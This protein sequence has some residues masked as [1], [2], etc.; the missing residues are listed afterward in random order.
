MGLEAEDE[1]IKK[2]QR[3]GLLRLA[4]A[5]RWS[6]AGFRSALR[7][8]E[9]FRQEVVLFV[10]LAPAALW[11]GRNGVERALLFGSLLVVLITELLNTAVESVVDRVGA[12]RH[13]LSKRAK[14]IGS[15]A[16]LVSLVNVVVTWGLV[17]FTG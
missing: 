6:L 7:H 14:D 9:A 5:L 16:V 17:L 11:L 1:Y 4:A 15:A 10:L 8:E 3:R 13:V 2:P 12:D